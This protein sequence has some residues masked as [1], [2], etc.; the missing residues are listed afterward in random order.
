M[1]RK[2]KIIIDKDDICYEEESEEIGFDTPTDLPGNP[3]GCFNFTGA[4]AD[5]MIFETK[6]AP[7]KI[8]TPSSTKNSRPA[9]TIPKSKPTELPDMRKLSIVNGLAPL[10]NGEKLDYK[11]SYMLR[12]STIKR[13]EQL[14]ALH[15]DIVYMSSLVD[16]A[17]NH[18]FEYLTRETR[19]KF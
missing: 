9:P 8:S 14:K 17:I 16:L 3:I 19:L 6:V 15:P 2:K 18:Y 10:V 12:F 13:L 1:A 11:R 7:N 4:A 5:E